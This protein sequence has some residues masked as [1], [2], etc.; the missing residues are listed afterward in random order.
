MVL[1]S[2]VQSVTCDEEIFVDIVCIGNSIATSCEVSPLLD[3]TSSSAR[4]GSV[5]DSS[6]KVID[7]S[8]IVELKIDSLKKNVKFMPAGIK[9]KFQSLYS[10]AITSSGLIHLDRDDMRQFGDD[11]IILKL[12]NNSIT[13]LQSDL[14]DFNKKLKE[15][16]LSEN[17]LQFIDPAF[18]KGFRKMIDLT[19][20]LLV[21]SGC[22]NQVSSSRVPKTFK[23]NVEK[24]VD[25]EAKNFNLRRIKGR[26]VFLT[27]ECLDQC[28]CSDGVSRSCSLGCIDKSCEGA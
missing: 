5:I 3:I 24:C 13:A 19:S 22:I 27:K 7:T 25:F 9:K 11:L 17:P 26:A 8:N 18:F 21:N 23:W 20:V 15:V 4:I 12:R 14:F 6:S 28:T 2:I 10:I 16:D 1:F